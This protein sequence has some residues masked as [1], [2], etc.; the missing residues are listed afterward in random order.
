[1][2]TYEFVCN[3]CG[4]RFEILTT[5]SQ[6]EKGLDLYCE[7]CGSPD[8]KQIISTLMPLLRET[9]SGGCC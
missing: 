6:K 3:Y 5:L 8:V 1:M 4:N 9:A 2:P 7:S